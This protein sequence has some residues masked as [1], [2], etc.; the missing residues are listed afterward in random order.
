MAAAAVGMAAAGV[1]AAGGGGWRGG[2]WGGGWRG[3]GWG[4][5]GGGG[6]G[7]WGCCGGWGLGTGLAV[8]ALATSPYWGGYYGYPSYAY[9]YGGGCLR[10]RPIYGARGQ[11]LG[12]RWV[13]VC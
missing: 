3:G 8:G 13:R 5:R 12:R 9:G 10:A 2:G 7:G 6:Y 11:Y 1:A 4:W